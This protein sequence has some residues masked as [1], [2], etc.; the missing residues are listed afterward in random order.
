MSRFSKV[1]FP[2]REFSPQRHEAHEGFEKIT[3]VGFVFSVDKV[4]FDYQ[5]RSRIASLRC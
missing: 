2:N 1:F 3:F 5:A 4:G